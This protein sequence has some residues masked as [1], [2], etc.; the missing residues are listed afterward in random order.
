[1]KGRVLIVGGGVMGTAIAI[2][3][4]RRTDPLRA[5]AVLFEK[6]EMGAGSSGHSG[7]IL[8]MFYADRTVALMARDSLREYA[9]FEARTGRSIGFERTG[10]MTLAGP[11]QP[12]WCDRI[13]TCVAELSEL[14]IEI[15]A[16]EGNEIRELVPGIR[17]SA[18]TV[19]AWEPAS[20]FVD[21]ARTLQSFAALARNYGAV[22]RVGV[23][24]EE[25]L[26]EGGKVV[27]ARTSE[28]D[29]TAGQ[30]VV[31]AGPW[32]GGILRALGVEIPLRIVQ[33][34]NHFVTMPES[35]V[36]E[37]EEARPSGSTGLSFDIEDPAEAVSEGVDF[38]APRGLHPVLIDLEHDFYCRCEPSTRR[39]RIGRADYSGHEILETPED[40]TEEISEETRRWSRE[41]LTRRMPDYEKQAD[42]G[43][44]SSWY[45]LTPDAQAVIG[46]VA[47]IEGLFVV[48][49]FSGHGFKLAP[50]VGEGLAQM[51]FDEPVTAFEPDFFAPDRF[52][53]D[54]EWGGRFGL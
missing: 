22:T 39:S 51:L 48:A 8:R 12:D 49:G 41:V 9:A 25:I 29:Y 50:A 2:E 28:G 27:G 36:S 7:A 21:P 47:G 35:E 46:P 42:A 26:V 34:E 53:G 24:V 30:V 11:D 6:S 40:R 1:M 16:V 10:V 38:L 13:R 20:G 17:V 54:E 5:P 31:V 45:T 43:S 18:S 19:G 14:G 37:T 15:R 3:T 4:A 23:A 52:K 44:L 32:S 33:P